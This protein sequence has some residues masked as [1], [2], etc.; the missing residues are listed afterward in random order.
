MLDETAQLCTILFGEKALG[1]VRNLEFLERTPGHG[2][3][4]FIEAPPAG[5]EPAT[6][7]LARKRSV[8]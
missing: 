4:F 8:H 3:P 1:V 2:G 5:L 7:I 6:S